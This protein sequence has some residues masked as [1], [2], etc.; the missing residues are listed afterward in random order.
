MK[1]SD[2]DLS[3]LRIAESKGKFLY[4]HRGAK[5]SL[6]VDIPKCT[7]KGGIFKSV[8]GRDKPASVQ[9]RLL[10]KKDNPEHMEFVQFMNDLLQHAVKSLDLSS[11]SN[12]MKPS[13]YDQDEFVM[14]STLESQSVGVGKLC[15]T[16]KLQGFPSIELS[17]SS[18]QMSG[19]LNISGLCGTQ[20]GTTFMRR[21]STIVYEGP[22]EI[23]GILVDLNSDEVIF[24]VTE[25]ATMKR[26]MENL[27]LCELLGEEEALFHVPPGNEQKQTEELRFVAVEEE[28][29]EEEE[30]AVAAEDENEKKKK[31][32]KKQQLE[33]H[34][35]ATKRTKLTLG[36][37]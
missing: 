12:P 13:T 15:L 5:Q 17:R 35:P 16:T 32:K 20:N 14:Y 8:F 29:E 33:Y 6:F 4:K 21:I 2:I 26:D 36:A 18:F 11:Y 30:V 22:P 27:P 24:D 25:K 9:I 37:E 3:K 28:E 1:P 34:A 19:T 31:K 7:A 23:Q 10:F